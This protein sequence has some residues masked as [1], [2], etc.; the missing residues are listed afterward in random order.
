VAEGAAGCI[1]RRAALFADE[2]GASGWAPLSRYCLTEL[3]DFVG[4]LGTAL[5]AVQGTAAS[6]AGVKWNTLQLSVGGA[7]AASRAQD[8]ALWHLQARHYRCVDTGACVCVCLL[9]GGGEWRDA[10]GGAT[11]L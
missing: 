3:R 4:V 10:V 9:R 8:L 6:G 5:P 1:N 2:T 7:Q 11:I